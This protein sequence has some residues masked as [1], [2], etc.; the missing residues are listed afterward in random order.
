MRKNGLINE[1][2]NVQTKMKREWRYEL[3][4]NVRLNVKGH[5]DECRRKWMNE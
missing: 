1:K 2:Q 5:S 4:K 3:E